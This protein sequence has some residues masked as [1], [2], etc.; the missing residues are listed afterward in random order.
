ME[1]TEQIVKKEIVYEEVKTAYTETK[2][3]RSQMTVSEGQKVILK[4]NI[5]GASNIKWVLNGVELTNSEQYRYGV[6]G[7]DQTLTIKKVSH[8]EGGSF[9]CEA[10]TE[11][12]LVKCHFEITVT[13]KRSDAPSFIVQPKSQNV[14][15]GQNVIITCEVTGEPSPEVEWLKDNMTGDRGPIGADGLAG[16]EG[17]RGIPGKRGLPSAKTDSLRYCGDGILQSENGEQCDDGNQEVSDNCINCQKA[18]CGDGHRHIGVE[19]CDLR[20]FGQQTCASYLPGMGYPGRNVEKIL[21][22]PVK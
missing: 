5:S 16:Q 7:D 8:K 21:Y 10:E 11:H 14:N 4:A 22:N 13:Q 2:V 3:S 1:V 12:G 18:F 19:Q 20:D 17:P 9:T 15:V 6:S